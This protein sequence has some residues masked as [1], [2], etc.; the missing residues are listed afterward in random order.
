MPLATRP[1]WRVLAG[2]SL[3]FVAASARAEDPWKPPPHLRPQ[4]ADARDLL[5]DAKARSPLVREMVDRLEQSDVIVYIRH[6]AMKSS[7]LEGWIG[8]LS[9]ASG[10]RYLVIEL[11][12]GRVWID[13]LTTL[14]H[15]LHHAVEIAGEPSVVDARSLAAFYD[16]IG[17][18]TGG[19][20]PGET[21]ETVAAHRAGQQVRRDALARSARTTEDK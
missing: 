12:C 3:L 14:G 13:Q 5:A 17:I 6:R 10:W 20:G 21:F 7:A 19:H 11:A 1:W 4:T 8:V 18:R 9:V 16:R 15:E 2:A